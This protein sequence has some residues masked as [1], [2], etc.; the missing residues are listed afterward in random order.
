MPK[1]LL[2]ATHDGE[3]KIGSLLLPCYVLED[4]IHIFS[5]RALFS[6]LGIRGHGAR[7]GHRIAAILK[8][9]YVNALVKKETWLNIEKP[10][11]FVTRGTETIGYK[12]SILSDMI[13]ALSQANRKG[14]LKTN[15]E[16]RYAVQAEILRDAL[17]NV[18]IDSLIDEVTG[19]Q[20][21]RDKKALQNILDKYFRKELSAWA[22]RFPDEFYKEIFRLKKWQWQGMKINRPGV[23]GTYTNDIVYE[24]LAPGL[25]KELES[26]N[27][28]N[29]I[30]KRKNRHHQWLTD[31]VGHP[32]LRDH[33][34]GV[35]A[36]M[37]GSTN[38]I[39]FCRALKN[40]YP[41][42]GDQS[43][44]PLND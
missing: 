39:G 11:R 10:I 22:K 17:V 15:A 27:P 12:S 28:T 24:R 29:H 25:L 42:T 18:A 20:E 32:K 13:N 19:Y 21:I 37:R 33:L 35:I 1:R 36:L 40:A 43:E 41:K 6:I 26:K 16:K 9:T 23:V 34:I 14:L 31:D 5:E 2:E 30:G 4:G 44:L 7:G 38:W 8:K 3:L